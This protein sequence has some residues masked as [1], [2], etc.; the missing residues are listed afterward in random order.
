[1]GIFFAFWL[2]LFLFL[3]DILKQ[4]W[5]REDPKD[6]KVEEEESGTPV[7]ASKSM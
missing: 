1:M 2:L 6:K 4:A 7:L 3:S 5:K